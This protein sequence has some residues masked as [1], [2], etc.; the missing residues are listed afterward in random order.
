MFALLFGKERTKCAVMRQVD[1]ERLLEI[2]I[3]LGVEKDGEKLLEH[4]LEEAMDITNCDG[5]T[6]YILHKDALEFKVMITKSLHIK[7]S[8]SRDEIKL[9]PVKLDRYNVCAYSVIENKLINIEDVYQSELFDFSGPLKYDAITGYR[10]KSM[11]VVPMEN[12][13]GEIIGVM[14]L[15]NARDGDGAFVAFDKQAEKILHAL[16]SQVAVALTNMNYIEEI[17]SLMESMVETISTAIHYKTPYNVTHT[18]SMV[19]YAEHFINFL[20]Q[21]EDLDWKFS[22]EKKKLFLMSIWLH[23]IGKLGTPLHIM[24]KA[25]RLGDKLERVETRFDTIAL[26]EENAALK[27]GEDGKA[28]VKEVEEAK[29]YVLETNYCPFVD[30]KRIEKILAI[31][32]R[33]YVDRTGKIQPWLTKEE[34][35]DLSIRKGTLTEAERRKMQEHVVMTTHILSK[36]DFKGSYAMVPTWASNHHEFL[37]GKGYPRGLTAADLDRESRLLTILDIFDGLTANDRPY[38]KAFTMEETFRI[39]EEMAEQ[40]QLDQ[41]V[42]GLFRESR[43]WRL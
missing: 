33:S 5:G 41:E 1:V 36:M 42:L 12:D 43:A 15:L 27:R 4:I 24:D 20:N 23:D 9:P 18:T 30:E 29:S 26:L 31:A 38:K 7:K 35:T 21:R 22:E 28:V 40:G 19:H 25:V 8:A 13:K 39:L 17:K 6:L 2:S 34:V 32:S 37:N 16:A 10:T 3:S 11:L 14:Q